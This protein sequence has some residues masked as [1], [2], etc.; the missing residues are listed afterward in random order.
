MDKIHAP[1]SMESQLAR[2]SGFRPSTTEANRLPTLQMSGRDCKSSSQKQKNILLP[3]RLA[4]TYPGNQGKL[5]KD[6]RNLRGSKGGI[7][8]FPRVGSR[9]SMLASRLALALA[10][11]TCRRPRGNFGG[12]S[13]R[14]GRPSGFGDG[15]LGFEKEATENRGSQQGNIQKLDI[16]RLSA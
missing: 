6:Q 15:I 16:Q 7:D 4:S 1:D 12:T 14:A 11:S 8:G 5:A 10:R 2:S 9:I 13:Q 3:T